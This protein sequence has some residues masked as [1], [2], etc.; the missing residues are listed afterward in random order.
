MIVRKVFALLFTVAV[1]MANMS[2]SSDDN[3]FVDDKPC[4]FDDLKNKAISPG[5]DFFRYCNGKWYDNT[6]IPEGKTRC[7][8]VSD[9][10]GIAAQTMISEQST[11]PTL[12]L[13]KTL[14]SDFERRAETKESDYALIRSYLDDI[15]RQ[16]TMHDLLVH[17]GR[18]MQ[19]DI[20]TLL[21]PDFHP[22]NKMVKVVL[23]YSM[24]GQY[25]I[26]S[27]D[28][29]YLLGYTEEEAKKIIDNATFV[30]DYMYD[31]V[32]ENNSLEADWNKPISDE[33]Y[34]LAVS[35]LSSRATNAD[36]NIS[37]M[38]SGM[39]L[40]RDFLYYSIYNE[41]GIYNYINKLTDR[42]LVSTRDYMKVA[43]AEYMIYK[44][45]YSSQKFENAFGN[46]KY[47]QP[48]LGKLFAETHHTSQSKQYVENMCENIRASLINRI[49]RLDWMVDNTK[50]AAADKVADM[51]FFCCYPENWN[52]ALVN[53]TVTSKSY[54]QD[55][56]ELGKQYNGILIGHCG[57]SDRDA[58]WDVMQ[59]VMPMHVL[60]ACYMPGTNCIIITSAISCPPLVD[61]NKSDAYNYGSIATIIGHEMTHG[62]D[63]DGC[64]YDKDGNFAV[65]WTMDDKLKFIERQ[66][67]LITIYNN[68]VV[69]PGIFQNGEQTLGENIADL[70]GSLAAYDSFVA[71]RKSQGCKGEELNAQKRLFFESYANL[72]REKRTLSS[73]NSQQEDDV[74]A[75]AICRI[76]GVVCNHPEW[77][78][79]YD[80]RPNHKLY[81]AP[82][83]RVSIW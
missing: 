45:A 21:T 24:R 51:Q 61:V 73:Y 5:D 75:N 20:P 42:Q 8:F 33:E 25:L 17:A 66:K 79:L 46:I 29:L 64:K 77:Y 1:C 10:Q 60:N 44:T 63:S 80:V 78:M 27:P 70:G 41:L 22:Q 52:D 55:V 34:N 3:I 37:I 28:V 40:S 11:N 23:Q 15:D 67:Q 57:H 6:V 62:L 68:L 53:P 35:H 82:E 48:M 71:L 65:W 30:N 7:G 58:I 36:D 16:T 69:V 59:T 26:L 4:N 38:L 72:W 14:K 47:V 56:L 9:E 31:I 39:G 83:R 43:V 32:T 49:G 76:N 18:L 13:F 50:R 54:L 19:Q 2:C 81:L 12:P 74:H